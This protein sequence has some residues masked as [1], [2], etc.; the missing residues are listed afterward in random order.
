M[1]PKLFLLSLVVAAA[2][3]GAFRAYESYQLSDESEALL[4]E[5][6]EALSSEEPGPGWLIDYYMGKKMIFT[7]IV[8]N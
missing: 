7:G 4:A 2:G 5:N 3:V 8:W 1:K 6:I